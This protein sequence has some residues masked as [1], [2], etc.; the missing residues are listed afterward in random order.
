MRKILCPT[1]AAVCGLLTVAIAI[2]AG[3]SAE[4]LTHSGTAF[5]G[6]VQVRGSVNFAARWTAART[7]EED[8]YP[9]VTLKDGGGYIAAVFV[10]D[11]FSLKGVGASGRSHAW[12][13]RLPDVLPGGN[14]GVYLSAGDITGTPQKPLAG[15]ETPSDLR[16]RI[17]EITVI[18]DYD[19]HGVAA[20]YASGT[21]SFTLRYTAR[22]QIPTACSPVIEIHNADGWQTDLSNLRMT[23]AIPPYSTG[24]STARRNEL[25][26]TGT[27]QITAN[28]SVSQRNYGKSYEIYA[29]MSAT[30]ELCLQGDRGRMSL[31]G[32]IDVAANG[33]VTVRELL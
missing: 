33:A 2:T 8:C 6:T 17:G 4:E 30:D 14:Y 11:A 24:W 12:V 7:V 27:T 32:V 13:M 19:V 10:D 9:A 21:L 26:N 23:S 15:G 3:G 20:S 31:V 28:A 29:G 25:N 18:G 5:D 16:Y 1:V 22:T